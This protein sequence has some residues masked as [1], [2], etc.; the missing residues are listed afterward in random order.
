MSRKKSRKV[1][2]I[3]VRKQADNKIVRTAS[4]RPKK[5]TGRPAGSRHSQADE[6]NNGKTNTADLDPRTGSKKLIS[7][8]AEPK[9]SN[10]KTVKKK[11]FSPREELDALESDNQLQALLDKLDNGDK[12]SHQ[13]QAFVDTSLARHKVL[14]KLLGLDQEEEE[15][16]D[17]DSKNA[18]DDPMAAL[19]AIKLDDYK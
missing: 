2:L 13:Q 19:D 9:Q 7:L 8:L 14:C 12:L 11:F 16:E 3:G 17:N 10:T 4:D 6:K 18:N 5:K 15:E 1:G